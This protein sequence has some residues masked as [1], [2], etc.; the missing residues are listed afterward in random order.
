MKDLREEHK[1]LLESYKDSEYKTYING[2][3]NELLNLL[4]V[5]LEIDKMQNWNTEFNKQLKEDI[6]IC[7]NLIRT[8][9]KNK[10][11]C[12]YLKEKYKE[13]KYSVKEVL[14]RIKQLSKYIDKYC[15]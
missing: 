7:M 8:I 9:S 13:E 12:D 6:F 11:V 3:S 4:F 2:Y 14:W 1:E 10:K 15:K 5:K